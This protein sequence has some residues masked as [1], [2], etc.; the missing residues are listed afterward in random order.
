MSK[1]EQQCETHGHN[2]M[3]MTTDKPKIICSKCGGERQADAT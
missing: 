1:A 3:V 2:Y